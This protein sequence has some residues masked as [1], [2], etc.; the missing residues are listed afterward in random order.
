M[1]DATHISWAAAR[2]N[3]SESTAIKLG[4]G[5]NSTVYR[6]AS[7]FLKIGVDL[8]PECER[9]QWLQGR[10]P[11]PEVVAFE[12]LNGNDALVTTAV[13]GVDLADLKSQR[14]AGAIVEMLA[15]ALREF[16]AADTTGCPFKAQIPGD[17]LVHGDACL[18]NILCHNG[19]ALSGFVDL[20]GMGV[21]DVE[22]D[23][24][25]AV[26]S[27]QYNLGPGHG[28]EFLSAYGLPNATDE[29]ADRLARMYGD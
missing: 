12:S 28:R 26:W 27:L 25:A 22:V 21:G 3:V 6:L 5:D 7:W 16:H 2:I 24:S 11:V 14:P 4:S 10:L 20:G 23:L 17:V 18:P 13:V 15:A 9:L 8:A 19:G 29:E 1:S